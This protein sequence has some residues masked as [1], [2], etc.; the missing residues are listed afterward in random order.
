MSRTSA[1]TDGQ[2]ER[3]SG[4]LVDNPREGCVSSRLEGKNCGVVRSSTGVN[5]NKV[6]GS[7]SSPTEKNRLADN[8]VHWGVD[9]EGA[10]GQSGSNKG[11]GDGDRLHFAQRR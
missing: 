3:C 5:A 10:L 7:S 11:K 9:S 2:V 4:S 6:W 1:V 8:G